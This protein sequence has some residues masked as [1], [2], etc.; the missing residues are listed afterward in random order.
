MNQINKLNLY[1][2][3]CKK[4]TE[5]STCIRLKHKYDFYCLLKNKERRIILSI[6]NLNEKQ[7][8]IMT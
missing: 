1:C 4:R 8:M 5:K 2:I 7:E 3:K 6:E